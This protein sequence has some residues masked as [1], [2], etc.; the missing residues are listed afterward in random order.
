LS[1]SGK[2]DRTMGGPPVMTTMRADG[3]QMVSEKDSLGG[4]WRRSVYLVA[5][6]TYP[7]TF[8]GVFDYPVIDASCTRRVPSATPLQSLT[9]LNDEFLL[10]NAGFL[11]ERAEQIAGATATLES[12]VA[13][14]YLLALSRAPSPVE[15]K[16]AGLHIERQRQ[17]YENANVQRSEATARSLASLAQI[18]LSSNEF[19]YSE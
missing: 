16:E 5:R 3:L 13:A 11:A 17:L 9:L 15:I 1:V 18:L 4:K 19:L 14:I 7:L 12:K 10:D 6:R 8:L 2:L